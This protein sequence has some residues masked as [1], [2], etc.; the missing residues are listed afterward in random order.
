MNKKN[1]NQIRYPQQR[2]KYRFVETQRRH[3]TRLGQ[4]FYTFLLHFNRPPSDL[5]QILENYVIIQ[6]IVNQYLPWGPMCL[7]RRDYAVTTIGL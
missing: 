7:E 2:N 5:E 1:F 3:E 4:F 6:Y